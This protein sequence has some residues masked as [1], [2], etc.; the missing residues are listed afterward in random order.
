MAPTIWDGEKTLKAFVESNANHPRL[1]E[2]GE[3]TLAR[4]EGD[5]LHFLRQKHPEASAPLD[6]AVA[7]PMRAALDGKTGTLLGKDYR[8]VEVLAAY[9]PVPHLGWGLVAKIDASE[10]RSP[11]LKATVA[12]ISVVMLLVI[13]GGLL[14]VQ[15]G[16]PLIRNLEHSQ[17]R[18]DLAIQGTSHG[19]W[20]W[21]DVS[22]DEQWWSPKLYELVGYATDGLT[23]S[24]THFKAFLH[25][26]DIDRLVASIGVTL[27]QRIPHD[28]EFRLRTKSGEYRWFRGRAKAIWNAEGNPIRMSGSI[29]DIN[30]QKQAEEA[31]RQSNEELQAIYDGMVDGV[32]IADAETRQFVRANAS[33]CKMLG[34]SEKEMLST[35]VVDIHPAKDLPAILED[36]QA[37]AEGRLGRGEDIPVL[38]KDGS[39]FCADIST[40]RTQYNGRPALIGIFRDVTERNRMDKVLRDSEEKYRTYIDNSPTG[41]F[42]VDATGRYVEVNPCASRLMGYTREELTR[43]SIPDI[44]APEDV[45]AAMDLF[46]DLLRTGCGVSGEYCFIRKDG[47]RFFMSVHAARISA[48]RVIGFCVDITDRKRVETE[49]RDAKTVA[50]AANKAKSEFLANMSHE[51]RTPMTAIL[52][53]SEMLLDDATAADVQKAG[54][55]IKRNGEHLLTII[56]DILDLSRI[57][58]GKEDIEKTTCSPRQIVEDVVLTMKVAADAK[59]LPL[60]VEGAGK[61]PDCIRT[62]PRRL[63]QILVNL[64]GNAIKF[65]EH[66]S[67]RIAMQL[68]ADADD[69]PKLRFDVIDTGIGLSEAQ[70]G[71]LFQPFSQVDGSSTRR[72]GGTGLGLAVSKRLATMLGGD[73][74]VTSIFGIGSTFSV[75]I[76]TGPLDHVGQCGDHSSKSPRSTIPEG[77]LNCRVLLAEDGPDNQRLITHILRKAG[78]EVAVAENG[79]VALDLALAARQAGNPFDVILMDMQMP[80]MD[81]Y[82]ATRQL[83]KAGYEGSVIALTASAMPKDRQKCL[84]AGCN[85]Y[86]TKPINRAMLLECVAKHVGEPQDLAV[87]GQS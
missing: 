43:M 32:L 9:A 60:S 75:T 16:K 71:F 49:L 64:V 30:K 83:R 46:H 17:E 37:Q 55:T 12:A 70:I 25:P 61:V 54:R 72:F 86:T 21:P 56:N 44:L 38:R 85:D 47:T 35:S 23:P 42:V 78:A 1:G 11:L 82:E 58:A 66:G 10:F 65:T 7:E 50:E 80:V 29:E 76:A 73:V 74:T 51:I 14:I 33:I 79:Q 28:I 40:Q 52:G 26:D 36:F 84:D 22:K 20:D 48:D 2:T 39:T 63:R 3:F 4:R 13:G 57:D 34:Y 19:L 81:G 41:I 87:V 45:P 53:F 69:E 62:D 67:V 24:L 8:G 5:S 27:N 18:L 6:K 31:L 77:R 15:L 59:G 68:V